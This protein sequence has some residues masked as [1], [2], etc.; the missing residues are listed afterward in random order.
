M[1]D[2]AQLERRLQSDDAYRKEFMK[3]P[4]AQ[5]SSLGLKLSDDQAR[6][7]RESIGGKVKT[8]PARPRSGII[9]VLIGL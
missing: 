1:V 3:D 2:L 5:L 9:A 6:F 4:V 8:T 7:L